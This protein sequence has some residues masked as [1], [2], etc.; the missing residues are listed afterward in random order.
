MATPAAT[1]LAPMNEQTTGLLM[2]LIDLGHDGR[3]LLD[4]GH[5]LRRE[6][7]H[8]HVDVLVFQHRADGRLVAV[9]AGVAD[10]VDRVAERGGG[11]QRALELGLGGVAQFG[12]LQ[13]VAHGRVGGH[14]AR[15][16]GVGD[17]RHAVALGQRLRGVEGRVVEQLGDRVDALHAALGQQGVV[18]RVG[19][20][21]RAGVAADGLGPFGR[22]ARLEAQHRLARFPEDLAAPSR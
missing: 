22:A 16:A 4:V 19:A 15:P 9:G 21:Q 8:A 11:R 3:R 20:G 7:H 12:Q 13:A 1:S 5:R 14:D 6:D 17:D 18:D 10:H 2:P